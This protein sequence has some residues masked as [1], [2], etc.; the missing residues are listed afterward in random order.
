MLTLA[1]HAGDPGTARWRAGDDGWHRG[2]SMVRPVA[3][4]LVDLAAWAAP[5]RTV[6]LVARR[7]GAHGAR[8]A[9]PGPI[10]DPLPVTAAQLDAHVA[11]VLA[12]PGDVVL[13]DVR[14]PATVE[15]TAGVG[16]ATP[17]Y[18]TVVGDELRGGWD[19]TALRR[20]GSAA[21]DPVL[22]AHYLHRSVPYAA[23]TLWCGVRH[24]TERATARWTGQRLDLRYPP[25]APDVPPGALRTGADPLGA[26]RGGLRA[27][28]VDLLAAQDGPAALELSGGADSAAVLAAARD[29]RAGELHTYGLLVP[30]RRGRLQAAR[31]TAL[32]DRFGAVD[33]TLAA[34]AHPPLDPA[35]PRLAG[36]TAL[37]PHEE[38]Y[39]E[40][41]DALLGIASRDGV[42]SMLTGTGGDELFLP[43]PSELGADDV[44][45]WP[46]APAHVTRTATEAFQDTRWTV[47]QAPRTVVPRSTLG[48]LAS[49]SPVFLRAGVLPVAP[50]ATAPVVRFCRQLPRSWRVDK[51][52]ER[53]YLASW[54]LPWQVTHPTTSESFGDF[55]EAT[56]R[57]PAVGLLRDLFR[58]P[59]LAD[60]GL[61]DG[62]RLRQD[63]DEHVRGGTVPSHRF[64]EVAALELA[65]RGSAAAA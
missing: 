28:L 58:D 33:R 16:S 23:T 61:V 12:D 36:G 29:A 46:A 8:G 10:P 40:A 35:G 38:I 17:L 26:F 48:S 31:R 65:L 39:T 56:L 5:G 57:G 63:L 41:F 27:L 7:G 25:A 30:G 64:Y 60:L 45:T 13:V 54:G 62:V 47:D 44:R 50:F 55:F 18:L 49:R 1:I 34:D 59:R 51:A 14:D 2:S 22:A 11:A 43:H 42:T 6:L 15:V 24:L 19:L 21:L 32:V 53:R 3:P 9:G 20:A 37:G 4:G 52:L